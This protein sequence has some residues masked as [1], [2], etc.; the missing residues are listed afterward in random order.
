[1]GHS[2]REMDPAGAARHDS[3]ID[4]VRR[5][6]EAV[7]DIPLSKFTAGDFAALLNLAKY[8]YED[9]SDENLDLLERRAA[10]E[11]NDAR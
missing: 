3:Y 4:R 8:P 7:K 1:M 5:V 9:M 11:K 10:E 2:W 6:R